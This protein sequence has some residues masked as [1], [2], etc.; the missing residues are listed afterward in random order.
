ML[1]PEAVIRPFIGQNNELDCENTSG[2]VK[3]TSKLGCNDFFK[4]LISEYIKDFFNDKTYN[5]SKKKDKYLNEIMTKFTIN[6]TDI[7]TTDI[8]SDVRGQIDEIIKTYI[9]TNFFDNDEFTR[10]VDRHKAT[11]AQSGRGYRKKRSRSKSSK[12]RKSLSIKRKK[13]RKG[14]TSKKGRKSRK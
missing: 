9:K 7:T 12:K 6:S 4:Y 14:R 13:Y 2:Q 5:V 11:Q 8:D 10:M 1:E 3:G